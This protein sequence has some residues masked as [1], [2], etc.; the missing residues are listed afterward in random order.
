MKKFLLAIFCLA[1][2][3]AFLFSQSNPTPFSLSGGN[4]S[5]NSWAPTEPAGT[6]PGSMVFHFTN[7]PSS[8]SF[9]A[10][11]NGN[12]DYDCSYSATARC[13]FNGLDNDGISVVSTS[14]AQYNDCVG[15]TA[16]ATRFTGAAVVAL[17]AS[18]RQNIS[19][20]FTGGTLTAGD[21]TTPREFVL[22]LQY[23]YDEGSGYNAWQDAPGPVQYVSNT[24]GHSEALGPFTLPAELNGKS[25][26]QLRWLYFQTALNAGGTR[27]RMRLDDISITS[28]PASAEFI[29]AP[30]I[31]TTPFC[32]S[33][34][35]TA[36][37]TAAFSATGTY[38]TTFRAQL[39]DENGSFSSP[40]EIGTLAVNDTDPSGSISITIPA[41]LVSG[42]AYKIRII[43]DSPSITGFESLP[44]Q[45]INGIGIIDNLTTAACGTTM[46]IAWNNP[47]SCFD[48]I[49]IVMQENTAFTVSPTGDGSGYTASATYGSG[50]AFENGFVIY[51]GISSPQNITG[52]QSNKH[53]FIAAYSRMG[54]DWSAAV[55]T[56]F[57]TIV[58]PVTNL[59]TT[60]GDAQAS[61]SWT[62]PSYCFDEVMVVIKEGAYVTVPPAGDGSAYTADAVYGTGTLFDGG[63]VM[64]KGIVSPQI[65]TG[66]T[67]GFT[68]Y[69]SV[70]TRLGSDWSM[71]AEINFLPA[72]QPELSSYILP[73]YMEGKT[74][75]NSQRVP[76]AF[77]AT[78]S[79]LTPDASYRY[80]CRAVNYT[81]SP[82]AGGA[83]GSIFPYDTAFVRTTSPALT[84]AGQYGEF[85][86]NSQGQ[87]TGWFIIEP[88]GNAKFTPGA[89]VKPRITL[90]DGNNGTS[91]AHRFTTAD[92][93]RV[94]QFGTTADTATG[95]GV[96]GITS[97]S[98]KNF[99]FLYDNSPASGR[100]LCGTHV[101]AC[102][103]D[104][105]AT[106]VY[107]A[108]YNATVAGTEGNW[109]GIVPNINSN[110]IQTIQELDI[111]GGTVVETLTEPTG[112]WFGTNTIS[113]AGGVDTPLII[114]LTVAVNAQENISVGCYFFNNTLYINNSD[115]S[116]S[117][118]TVYNVL[119]QIVCSESTHNKSVLLNLNEGTYLYHVRNS[120]ES[121]TGKFVVLK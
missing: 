79:N 34:T 47:V 26:I 82:T 119:G 90:N 92:S 105:P 50:T 9:D 112:I 40:Q 48:E 11:A 84:T 20:S 113:P 61:I 89:F 14:S 19:V 107:A 52:I 100:P 27:P 95:T 86:T 68:Y 117:Q 29:D 28:Q 96:I 99:V 97:F 62:A 17:N 12:A 1:L 59:A 49:M 57:Y 88:T 43:S 5:F 98:S 115:E 35:G 66:F 39:S 56:D 102:G 13:R 3:P 54:S 70:F 116:I 94:L 114:D 111:N 53:Y 108:F 24:T 38:N 110:G 22:R 74:P 75:T 44:F 120:N 31:S 45:I 33:A 91:P 83:G 103:I 51:K 101:E 2:V 25:N 58:Q 63:Y 55:T 72:G 41:G 118:V 7:D 32:V 80:F 109:G 46:D 65:F 121:H 60:P 73:Q 93:V 104:F 15:G 69:A 36:T 10:F 71:A 21:G 67:N 6:F 85:T 8:V 87:Y 78:L 16:A 77:L 81:D 106:S 64:Y 23:R 37:G 4:F 30:L 18:G 42:T 76:F